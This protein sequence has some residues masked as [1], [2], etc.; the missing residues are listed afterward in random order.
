[1][2]YLL[3]ALFLFQF[4]FQFLLLFGFGGCWGSPSLN[5]LNFFI[6]NLP[7]IATLALFHS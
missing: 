1:M 5:A 6:Y 7:I 2:H 3:A 4:L